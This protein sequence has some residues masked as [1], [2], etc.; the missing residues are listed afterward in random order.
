MFSSRILKILGTATV[1]AA[2]SL[3][4]G[5]IAAESLADYD[6]QDLL[7]GDEKTSRFSHRFGYT[8]SLY[9]EDIVLTTE[10]S[11]DVSQEVD[12]LSVISDWH[13]KGGLF[14]LSAGLVYQEDSQLDNYAVEQYQIP[15]QYNRPEMALRGNQFDG[16]SPYLGLGW[17]GSLTKSSRMGLNLD[18]GVLYQPD[19]SILNDDGLGFSGDNKRKWD[20]ALKEGLKELDLEPVFSLGVSYNF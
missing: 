16:I 7:E 1:L 18:V 15:M 5:P 3:L 6:V 8:G 11:P 17:G 19:S 14:R 20:D 10:Q 12:S 2:C 4:C 13:P 9:H